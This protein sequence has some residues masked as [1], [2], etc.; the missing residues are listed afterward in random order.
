METCSPNNICGST[1]FSLWSKSSKWVGSES[2]KK[3]HCLIL[4]SELWMRHNLN[5]SKS[6]FDGW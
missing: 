6:Y 2:L 3:I 4:E 5:G 1:L